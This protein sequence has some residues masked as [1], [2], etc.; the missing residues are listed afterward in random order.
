SLLYIPFSLVWGMGGAL[1]TGVLYTLKERNNFYIFLGGFFFG[2]VFE[3]T[4]S[5]LTE[6]VFGTIFWD[7]SHIPFN[8]NG[9]INLL[10]CFVW[11]FL[12]IFWVKVLYP[13]VSRQIEKI[14]PVSGMVLTYIIMF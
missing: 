1:I 5:A 2:G 14:P 4:C 11:G 12:A 10:F 9:R 3:Y 13:A 7:Y 6:L 8:L